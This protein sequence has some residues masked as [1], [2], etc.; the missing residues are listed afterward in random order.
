MQKRMIG[1]RIKE[2]RHA[3]DMTQE[4]LAYATKMTQS[5]ISRYERG[6]ND[7]TGE[8]ISILAEALG[9]SSDYLLGGTDD[10]SPKDK[11]NSLTKLEREIIAALR[12]GD[13]SEAAR[14]I[15]NS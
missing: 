14:I 2:R 6:E 8:S 13:K 12:R 11:I 4:D 10:P 9:T 5:Q 15:L 3:L 7:P 1:T